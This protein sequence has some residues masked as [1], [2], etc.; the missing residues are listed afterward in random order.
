MKQGGSLPTLEAL[1]TAVASVSRLEVQALPVVKA[2]HTGCHR[3]A[4]CANQRVATIRPTISTA[5]SAASSL[6][7]AN[8][9]KESE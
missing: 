6:A 5:I 9:R 3:N 2:P 1:T 4:V 8:D 7:H